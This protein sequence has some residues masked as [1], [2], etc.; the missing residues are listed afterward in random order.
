MKTEKV[1][2]YIYNYFYFGKRSLYITILRK[3][4][5]FEAASYELLSQGES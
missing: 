3:E 5:T 1:Y 2:R 4:Y